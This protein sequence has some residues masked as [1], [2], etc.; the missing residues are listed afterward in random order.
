MKNDPKLRELRHKL[1]VLK[2]RN[3]SI[4]QSAEELGKEIGDATDSLSALIGDTE[5]KRKRGRPKKGTKVPTRTVKK[6]K[7]E[8]KTPAPRSNRCQD[9]ILGALTKHNGLTSKDL[10]IICSKKKISPNT[11]R[12]SLADMARSGKL[13]R[14]DEKRPYRYFLP[15]APG[16]T[17]M[18][19]KSAVLAYVSEN[20]NSVTKNILRGVRKRIG[21]RVA[22]TSVSWALREMTL[23]KKIAR[24]GWPFKYRISGTSPAV[25]AV[26]KRMRIPDYITEALKQKPRSNAVQVARSVSKMRKKKISFDTARVYLLGMYRCG[27]VERSVDKPYIYSLKD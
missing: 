3:K 15:M 24:E 7:P 18:S 19:V 22:D 8:K 16:N 23:E 1:A 25:D 10:S 11:V 17:K 5:P 9:V 12:R 21:K 27:E 6:P 13:N 26:K 20:P 4:L 2:A 14:S